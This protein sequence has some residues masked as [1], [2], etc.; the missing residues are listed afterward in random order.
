MRGPDQDCTAEGRGLSDR[1][2]GRGRV[3]RRVVPRPAGGAARVAARVDVGAN[4]CVPKLLPR[5]LC[6]AVKAHHRTVPST[7]RWS[8]K[9]SKKNSVRSFETRLYKEFP[10]GAVLE[11]FGGLER[12]GVFGGGDPTITGM[13]TGNG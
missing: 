10:L 12:S 3:R 6:Q 5:A 1:L 8:N 9:M 11:A 13:R 4:H 2:R 7:L